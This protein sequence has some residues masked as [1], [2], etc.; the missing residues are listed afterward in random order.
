LIVVDTSVWIDHLHG[1]EPRLVEMLQGSRVL[2]HPMIIGELSLGTLHD[3]SRVVGLLSKLPMPM[4]ARHAEVMVMVD[5]ESFVRSRPQ[6]GRRSPI[7]IPATDT[8]FAIV[9][10]RSKASRRRG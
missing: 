7:G 6:P 5:H 1:A 9:D 10:T 8:R 3:R 4:A 2:Q